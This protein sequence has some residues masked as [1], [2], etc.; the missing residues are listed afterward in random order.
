[1]TRTLSIPAWRLLPA[2][3][4]ALA[5]TGPAAWAQFKV[6]APDG[7]VTYTDR[8]AGSSG[9]K[10]VPLGRDAAAA[11]A[12]FATRASAPAAVR[13]LGLPYELRLVV[14]RFPVTLYAAA[15]CA[16]C[17][18]GRRL[19]QQRGVPFAERQVQTEDD[20]IALAR[21]S[22]ARTVPVLAVGGQLS[23]GWQEADWQSTLELAGYP[24]ESRLPSDWKNPSPAPLTPRA[25]DEAQARPAPRAAAPVN[26]PI[27]AAS[28]VRF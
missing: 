20:L 25:E 1:M 3:A 15:D 7:T 26:P 8:P 11:A 12:A 14:E 6:V 13:T 2:L 17:D 19:L 21:L 9:T 4:A 23:R 28:G 27:D 16:P 22:G 24:R 18:I 10:V 5:L